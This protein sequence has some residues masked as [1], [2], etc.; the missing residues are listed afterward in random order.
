M[1]GRGIVVDIEGG[2]GSKESC[3]LE[4]L[5]EKVKFCL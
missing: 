5:G 1:E 4:V 2:Y 3:E